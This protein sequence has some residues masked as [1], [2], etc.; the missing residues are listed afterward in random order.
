[1]SDP[2]GLAGRSR[3]RVMSVFGT[4]PE[5]IKMAPVIK[6]LSHFPDIES[7]VLVTAQH[8]EMLDQV[9]EHFGITPDYDLDIMRTGQTLEEITSRALKGVMQ[10]LSEAHPDMVLVHGDTTTTFAAALG[11]FYSH[12]K[13][14]HVEAGLR[15]RNKYS[16]FPEEM[17]RHLTGVLA[18]AH[19]AP[20]VRA[21]ENLLKEGID[22]RGIWITGNTA[23][24]A[25]LDTIREGHVFFSPFLQ[26]ID[27]AY[28]GKR[29]LLA[30]VHR[31]E[32]WGK[33]ME[34]ICSALDEVVKDHPDVVLLFSVHRNPQVS[35]VVKRFLEGK[36]RVLLFDPV[37]YPDWANLM[38]KAY[39]II[40]DS[41]GVQEEAPALGKPVVLLRDTTE[42]P[43]ALE[44]GTVLKAGTAKGDVVKAIGK[45]LQDQRIYGSMA[46]AINPY[47]DG[48]AAERIAG[49]IRWMFGLTEV[50][51]EQYLVREKDDEN[52]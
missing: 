32:N 27:G 38:S 3:I 40:T 12:I 31:R 1:M 4:R 47:G 43:E 18:D 30:E 7:Q 23:I 35:N 11:A 34:E 17:N 29:L 36:D 19:F 50:K 21:K 16:P 52:C 46:K 26:G 8:R 39:L 6:S 22:E 2:G 41:G 44:A 24:D 49:A 9:L 28:P 20:T 25:L 10:V 14:G 5:A 51:P 42:R 48:R 13:V 15:T 33:P 45:L 37:P